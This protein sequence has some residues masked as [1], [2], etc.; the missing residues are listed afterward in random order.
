[1]HTARAFYSAKKGY[2]YR[3]GSKKPSRK[4]FYATIEPG[5]SQTSENR[6]AGK[7][8]NKIWYKNAVEKLR[9]YA[10]IRI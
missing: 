10:I 6:Q 1:M 5:V 7:L 3:L 2:R 4:I 8:Q 9:I